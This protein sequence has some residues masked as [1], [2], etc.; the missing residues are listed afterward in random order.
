MKYAVL[1]SPEHKLYTGLNFIKGKW[2]AATGVH[3]ITGLYTAL[4]P[5]S[6]ENYVLWNLRASYQL[7][8]WLDIYIKGENLLNQ[9]YDINLG[10]PMPGANNL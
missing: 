3:A 4:D 1:A 5:K 9:K 6:K 2:S 7:T 10:F 8:K